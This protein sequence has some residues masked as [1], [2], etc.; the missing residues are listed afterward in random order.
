MQNHRTKNRIIKDKSFSIFSQILTLLVI[1]IFIVLVLF[2]FIRSIDGWKEYGSTIFSDSFN[3]SATPSTSQASIWLPLSITILVTFGS[4]LIATPLGI[5][6]AI[7]LKFRLNKRYVKPLLIIV[8]LLSAIPSVVFGL[9]A[10]SSLG[11]FLTLLLNT[12]LTFSVLNAIIMLSFMVLPTIV[13]LVYNALDA[14][15]KELYLNPFAL[16]ST[17]NQSI[18]KIVL[19]ESRKAI[20]VAVI[21]AMGRS[22]GETMALNFI[23]VSQNF[24]AVFSS[25]QNIF[26]T[27]LKTLGAVISFNYF[28]ENA[29]MATRS[30]LNAFGILLLVFV[31]ILNLF[32]FFIQNKNMKSKYQFLRKIETK[33]I[34]ILSYIPEHLIMFFEYVFFKNSEKLTLKNDTNSSK[35]IHQRFNRKKLFLINKWTKITT[36]FIAFSFVIL[37]IGWILIFI[38]V[39]GGQAISLPTQTIT[40]FDLDS[41]GR[42]IVNTIVIVVIGILIAFPFTLFAAIY[43]VEYTKSPRFR[44]IVMFFVDALGSTP[45]ILF[46]IFGVTFFLQTLGLAAGGPNSNSLLAGILTIVIVIIPT[47]IRTIEQSLSS[48]P[49]DVRIN[50]YALGV[51]KVSTIFKI[52]LPLALQGIITAIILAISRIMSE[53]AP[54]FLTAGLTSSNRFNFL[55]PGQSL[56]TRIFAQLFNPASNAQDIMYEA[57]FMAILLILVFVL[58]SQLIIPLSFQHKDKIKK[59][60]QKR[61]VSHAQATI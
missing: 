14:V 53:T 54:L 51:S 13:L 17:K 48:V 60:F 1:L 16:G 15:P 4:L 20:I 19:K 32:V 2:I 8:N 56:T 55:L 40:S 57:S 37:F 44:N 29:T 39:R 46:A 58:I 52:V 7:F 10:T 11:E 41:T 18:Y 43:L 30:L 5:K 25:G 23:L 35:F 47:F 21:I 50:A 28:G 22:I 3:L 34:K 12:S 36:E 6:S 38:L 31:I 27:S 45:S 61:K 59:L 26:V 49:D 24:N 33:V 42:A 9:F